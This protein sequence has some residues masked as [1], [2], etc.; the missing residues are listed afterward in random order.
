MWTHDAKPLASGRFHHHPSPDRADTLGAQ[1]F[2]PR[3]FRLE[4][5]DPDFADPYLFFPLN[6]RA[7]NGYIHTINRVLIP[8]DL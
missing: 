8:V 5:N 3:Y 7:S 6:V 1:R 4:D 2:Q